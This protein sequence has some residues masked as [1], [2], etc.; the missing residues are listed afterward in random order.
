MVPPEGKTVTP[1]KNTKNTKERFAPASWGRPPHVVV[2]V[3]LAGTAARVDGEMSLLPGV[4]QGIPL[5]D[6]LAWLARATVE[7]AADAVHRGDPEP[8]AVTGEFRGRRFEAHPTRHADDAVVWWLV[9]HTARYAA[10]EALTAERERTRFL[11]EASNVLL[12]SVLTLRGW[13][14]DFLGAQVPT[15]HLVAHLHSTGADAV[16]LSSSIA[17]RLPT[18]HTAITACQAV[19]VPVL[20]G[21]AAFGADGRYARLLGADAWA[22]DVRAAARRLADGI[23]APGLAVGRRETD[24]LA[25]KV[26]ARSL[27]PALDALGVEL[28]DFPRA[29]RMLDRACGHLDKAVPTTDQHPGASA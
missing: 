24:G 21:G 16:A 23:P 22:P 2:V 11:A 20:A 8:P 28:K 14:V 7:T 15:P 6:G 9:D 3:D 10:E 17:T 1:T 29:T 19:G 26:P 12:S 27:R 4:E 13:K 5:P 25:R 18:A